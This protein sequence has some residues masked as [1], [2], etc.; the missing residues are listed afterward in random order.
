MKT[1]ARSTNVASL[2]DLCRR[3]TQILVT[4]ETRGL[5]VLAADPI[6]PL[7]PSTRKDATPHLLLVGP[8]QGEP[9]LVGVDIYAGIGFIE[10]RK[11][12]NLDETHYSHG[13]SALDGDGQE[14][15]VSYLKAALRLYLDDVKFQA[16]NA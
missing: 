1:E 9:D 8:F 6:R 15:R 7:L 11:V 3:A 12:R 10:V 14:V 5:D 2:H 4:P 16:N 13:L